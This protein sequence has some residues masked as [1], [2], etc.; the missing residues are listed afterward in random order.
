FVIAMVALVAF[1]IFYYMGQG[2]IAVFALALNAL[3]IL[4][5]LAFFNAT[6]TLPGMAGLILTMG[7]AVDANVLVFERIR[8]ELRLGSSSRVAIDNGYLKA[9]WTI[10]DSNITTFLT[11]IILYNFGTG[12][13]KGFALTLM[14]GIVFTVFTALFAA[15]VLT[16]LLT[17]KLDHISVGKLTVFQNAKFPFINFR[18]RAYILSGALIL[19]GL[20][21]L[22]AHGGPRYSI[23][24]K[25]GSLMELHFDKPVT[26]EGIRDALGKVDVEGTDFGTSEIQFIGEGNQ[27]VLIRVVQVGNMQETSQK[28]KTALKENLGDAVPEDSGQ[29][30]LREEMVGPTIWNELRGQAWKAILWSLLVLLIYITIRFEFKYSL[31]AILAL[32]HDTIIVVGLFSL[33]GEEISLTV[34]AA[35]LALIGYSLND[36]IVVFDRIRE[37][38]RK[39]IQG[40]YV[41]TLDSAINETLARTTITSL[42]TLIAVLAL[43]FFGGDVIHGFS[44]ALTIGIIVGTY[45]SIF[46][47]APILVEW[48]NHVDKKRKAK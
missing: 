48:Y 2:L 8:E 15:K 47:A 7:M 24:F 31:G 25:G 19:V 46:V 29:W 17:S 33:L 39:G 28:I 3:F 44:L 26:I 14:V 23:D 11:G 40:G 37:K 5:Y 10:L 13:V 21:S 45:S 6:L 43:F 30:V 41:Q 34:I 35:I 1:M 20:I 4:A 16:D 36:T 27:D 9:R 12:P 32:A 42:T 18:K 38:V 22:I